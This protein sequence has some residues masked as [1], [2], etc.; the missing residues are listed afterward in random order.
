MLYIRIGKHACSDCRAEHATE[1]HQDWVRILEGEQ[2]AKP[3]GEILIK[4]A[5]KFDN[6]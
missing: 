6:K 5:H 4:V 3:N 1:H 2:K